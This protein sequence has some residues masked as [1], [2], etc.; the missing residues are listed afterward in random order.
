MAELLDV[1]LWLSTDSDVKPIAKQPMPYSCVLHY[2]KRIIRVMIIMIILVILVINKIQIMVIKV[3]IL[4]K[5]TQ[6]N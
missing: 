4:K 6:N 1:L 2:S 5:I 3:I